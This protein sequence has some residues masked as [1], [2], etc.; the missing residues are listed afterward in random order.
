MYVNSIVTCTGGRWDMAWRGLHGR[1]KDVFIK[2]ALQ[3]PIVAV[4][5][6]NLQQI[7]PASYQ[8]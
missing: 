3:Q 8:A 2:V 7:Q 6:L 4:L 1:Q 5:V